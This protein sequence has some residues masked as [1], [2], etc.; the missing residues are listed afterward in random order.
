MPR[1]NYPSIKEIAAEV[2]REVE[3]EDQIKTAE[4]KALQD[5]LS[6]RVK[7]SFGQEL[8]KL[9]EICRNLDDTNP[10]VTVDDITQFIGKF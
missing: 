9:A 1:V 8:V 5:A 6:P 7:T 2:L 4:L 3:A 10:V